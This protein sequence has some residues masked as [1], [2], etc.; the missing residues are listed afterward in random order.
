MNILDLP[1][2]QLVG[3][4]MV[5]V[6]GQEVLCLDS[7]AK[8]E[9]H[10]GTVHA[11]AL[12]SLAEAASG[13]ALLAHLQLDPATA[14]AVLRSARVKYRQP[15]YGR[16]LAFAELPPDSLAKSARQLEEKG[17]TLMDVK[18]RVDSSDHE[19]FFAEFTWLIQIQEN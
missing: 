9:N 12:F 17:R 2:N 8:H 6:E 11:S 16:L 19:V 18:V 4:Q 3:L 10:L 14:R 13:H 15:A 5:E 7:R 1:F